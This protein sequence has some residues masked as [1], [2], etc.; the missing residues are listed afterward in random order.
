MKIS[1]LLLLCFVFCA[2]SVVLAQN[3][4]ISKSAYRADIR[5]LEKLPA[6]T[7]TQSLINRL[8]QVDAKST[9]E[10]ELL[11]GENGILDS[12]QTDVRDFIRPRPAIYREKKIEK[13]ITDYLL[14]ISDIVYVEG[15]NLQNKDW[16]ISPG[17]T[18]KYFEFDAVAKNVLNFYVLLNGYYK[19]ELSTKK[20]G[21]SRRNKNKPYVYIE[22]RRSMTFE[23]YFHRL[24]RK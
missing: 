21:V 20:S 10:L 17:A 18:Y 11:Q 8:K 23:N 13:E 4:Y 12:L 9:Q 2:S 16:E 6:D 1:R 7:E 24:I 3:E 22:Y 19:I 15:V 14:A 5:Y